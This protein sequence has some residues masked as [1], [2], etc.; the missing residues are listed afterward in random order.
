MNNKAPRNIEFICKK[1]FDKTLRYFYCL[2]F[3]HEKHK[4]KFKKNFLFL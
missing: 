1:C 2:N 3:S 4:S